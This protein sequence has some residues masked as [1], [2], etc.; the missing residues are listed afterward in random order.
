MHLF[1]YCVEH[2]PTSDLIL[3]A[4][5]MSCFVTQ[6]PSSQVSGLTPT[7]QL[8][9]THFSI[10]DDS[11]IVWAFVHFLFFSHPHPLHWETDIVNT[12]TL[13][14]FFLCAEA[15]IDS[16]L[17]LMWHSSCGY[18][19]TQLL[20]MFSLLLL[21]H[22]KAQPALLILIYWLVNSSVLT[23]QSFNLPKDC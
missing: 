20:Q 14:L 9:H 6:T 5:Q 22:R 23:L 19:G 18:V 7:V 16:T 21:P 3:R 15:I 17:C 11:C 13:T 4:T 12:V 8:S 1:F 2:R 10:T